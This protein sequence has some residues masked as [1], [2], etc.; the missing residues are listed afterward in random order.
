[1][2]KILFTE[3]QIEQMKDLYLKTNSAQYIS[4]VM[5]V[6]PNPIIGALRANGVEVKTNYKKLGDVHRKYDVDD[7]FFEKIDSRD[8]AYIFGLL[9]ADGTIH[10]KNASIKLKL[11]DIELVKLVMEKMKCNRPL[12]YAKGWMPHHKKSAALVITNIKMHEDIQKLGI[13]KQKSYNNV[14]PKT[15]N[16]YD[17]DFMRGFFDGNGNVYIDKSGRPEMSIMSTIN[18]VNGM[19]DVLITYGIVGRLNIPKKRY[20]SRIG[21]LR[22]TNK[23]NIIKFR[24][25]VYHNIN[26]Q[27]F[28]KRKFDKLNEVKGYII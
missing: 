10:S 9:S 20:D 11:C 23:E 15:I 1:M 16:G 22:I 5:G 26:G 8:K 18:F 17:A 3:L 12:Y 4:K 6:S 13:M 25:F 19:I 27:M 7:T 28:L 2:G 14:Y 21:S 24:E